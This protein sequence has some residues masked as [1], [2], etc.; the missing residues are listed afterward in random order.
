MP[1]SHLI[2][3]MNIN[4]AAVLGATVAAIIGREAL[5]MLRWLPTRAERVGFPDATG[6]LGNFFRLAETTL[7]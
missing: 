2:V 1:T 5:P 7:R 6:L 3:L 4:P